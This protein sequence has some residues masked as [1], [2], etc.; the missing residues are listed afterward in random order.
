MV[1][2]R[3]L[4]K[5]LALHNAFKRNSVSDERYSLSFH[6]NTLK[7]DSTVAVPGKTEASPPQNCLSRENLIPDGLQASSK[8]VM[9]PGLAMRILALLLCL[10]HENSRQKHQKPLQNGGKKCCLQSFHSF[11]MSF[12]VEAKRP[13]NMAKYGKTCSN[14][15]FVEAW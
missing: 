8:P 4:L 6:Y 13:A 10:L 14:S 7:S 12:N 3:Q 5:L 9:G 15:I 11:Q 1:Y 2:L